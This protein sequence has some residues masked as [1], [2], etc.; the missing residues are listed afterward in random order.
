M[1]EAFVADRFWAAILCFAPLFFFGRAWVLT[2]VALAFF[3]PEAF[4]ALT[5]CILVCFFLDFFRAGIF[6]V[7]HSDS[8]P[9]LQFRNYPQPS[10]KRKIPVTLQQFCYGE[11]IH[12][13]NDRRLS[14]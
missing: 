2:R 7:Y 11:T 12:R 3:R 13:R 14:S 8:L 5:L 6:A 9:D 1:R 4:F 10:L